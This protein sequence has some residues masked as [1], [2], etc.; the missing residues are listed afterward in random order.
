VSSQGFFL[1]AL[2]E[3]DKNYDYDGPC[4]VVVGWALCWVLG[5]GQGEGKEEG[6]DGL[7]GAHSA[8]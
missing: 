1:Y 4:L 3:T 7:L 8:F 2:N 5:A 6:T